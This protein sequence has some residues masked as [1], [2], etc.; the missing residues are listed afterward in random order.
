MNFSE[1]A[2]VQL[3]SHS[4]SQRLMVHTRGGGSR[5]NPGPSDYTVKSR[6][7]ESPR[8]TF[9]G[10]HLPQL[11][12]STAPYR[13]LP[14]LVGEGPKISLSSRHRVPAGLNTPGPTYLQPSLGSD[15]QK[16]GMHVRAPLTRDARLDNPGPGTYEPSPRFGTGAVKYTLKSRVTPSNPSLS[17]G[18]A[19]YSPDYTKTKVTVPSAS[20][21]IRPEVPLPATTPGPS[22]YNV[23]RDLAG[24]RSTLHVRPYGPSPDNIPGP[25]SYSP[26]DANKATSP[27]YSFKSRPE[28][29]EHPNTAPYREIPTKVGEGPKISLSSRHRQLGGVDTPGPT[30][31]Q[32]S[33]GSDA[34]KNV[35]H[36]RPPLPRNG[37]IDNP[38]PGAYEHS[39]RF[40]NEAVK[41][42]LKSRVG[43]GIQNLS[44]GPAAY[45]PDY[46]KTK[47]R[48]PAASMHIRPNDP[49]PDATSGY[50]K[51]PST[52]AGPK[53]S[54]GVRDDIDVM[55][56]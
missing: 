10:R 4:M 45:S 6:I 5:V 19:A 31:I 20:M 53:W 48:M 18:P 25:G 55:P 47:V 3:N 52:L 22:D 1:T 32:P 9:K 17:P 29:V 49:K 44:P 50:L 35:M 39:P 13:G 38:G 56:L 12:I 36:V 41:Y 34:Q 26:T 15:A 27:R 33:L 21:H 16:N 28:S 2:N 7:G 23:S 43:L 40:G 42:T 30:Y 11:D 8:W 51:L 37:T 24:Q 46:T 54:I 14:T